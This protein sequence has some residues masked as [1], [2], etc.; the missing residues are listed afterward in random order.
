MKDKKVKAIVL[1]VDSGGGSYVAS[2]TI[3]HEMY[4]LIFQLFFFISPHLFFFLFIYFNVI[5]FEMI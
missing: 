3:Y 2:D 5:I 4:L 1:R